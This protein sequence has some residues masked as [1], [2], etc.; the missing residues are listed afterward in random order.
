VFIINFKTVITNI[1]LFIDLSSQSQIL[2]EPDP[3][4]QRRRLRRSVSRAVTYKV[5]SSSEDDTDIESTSTRIRTSRQNKRTQDR[6]ELDEPESSTS[7][8]NSSRSISRPNKR[9][10]IRTEE[11]VSRIILPPLYRSNSPLPT[12][13]RSAESETIQDS[14]YLQLP[15]TGNNTVLSLG[16]SSRIPEIN[17]D[18][19][20]DL[21][22][23]PS[24]PSNNA[25]DP[26]P[27]NVVDLTSSPVNFSPSTHLPAVN[28]SHKN[29]NNNNNHLAPEI[30]IIDDDSSAEDLTSAGSPLPSKG[31]QLKCSICLDY[32]K[33]VSFTPCGHIFCRDCIS[34]ALKSQKVCSLCRRSLKKKQIKRLEFKI[35]VK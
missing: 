9:R 20:V 7:Y 12:I 34:T 25:A 32:P 18:E 35:L 22:S 26:Y 1:L 8:N 14:S 4:L 30:I 33:D 15:T 6:A 16:D 23:P 3:E 10:A 29:S 27:N 24:Y 11:G 31:L 19:V 5:S 2:I 17:N 28:S 21:S 13:R